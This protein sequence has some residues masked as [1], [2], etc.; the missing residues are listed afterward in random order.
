MP[1][2]QSNLTILHFHCSHGVPIGQK[3]AIGPIL[4]A[5]IMMAR[6]NGA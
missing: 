5:S 3:M 2:P 6:N 1:Y 4:K